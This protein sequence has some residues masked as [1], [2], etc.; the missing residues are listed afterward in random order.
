MKDITNHALKAHV[1]PSGFARLCCCFETLFC[2]MQCFDWLTHLWGVYF[3]FMLG[4]S[5]T[6]HILKTAIF[7]YLKSFFWITGFTMNLGWTRAFKRAL[8]DGL[9]SPNKIT[10]TRL[11]V[12][13][14]FPWLMINWNGRSQFAPSYNWGVTLESSVITFFALADIQKHPAWESQDV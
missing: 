5:V 3:F 10:Q 4:Q 7:K 14:I 1:H 12:D 8:H 9:C 2:Q 11:R 6:T 13:W